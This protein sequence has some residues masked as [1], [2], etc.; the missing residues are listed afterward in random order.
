MSSRKSPNQ[1]PSKCPWILRVGVFFDGTGNNKENDIP[2]GK[3]TNIAKLWETYKIEE[4]TKNLI[5]YRRFYKN[6]VGTIDGDD[7][8]VSGLALG[9]GGIE[10]V[11]EAIKEVADFFDGKPCAKEFVV[12]VFGFSRGA[13]QAR[14]FIN[15]LHDR[16]AGPNVKVGFVGIYDTV[17]SFAGGWIGALDPTDLFSDDEAGDNINR[18]KVS[19]YQGQRKVRR[20][21]RIVEAPYYKD[22][23]KDFNFHLSSASADFI[24]HFVARDEVRKNFPLSSLEPNDGGFL[25]QKTYIGVHSDIGG[26]YATDEGEIK[27]KLDW[28]ARYRPV[29]GARI[30]GLDRAR[31]DKSNQYRKE[32]RYSEAEIEEIKQAYWKLGYDIREERLGLKV[33]LVG[34]KSVANTLSNVYLRLMHQ[35]ACQ[36]QVP[37]E[38]LPEGEE[39]DIPSELQ[40]YWKSL[41]DNDSFPRSCEQEIYA[42]FVHQSDV[43]DEDRAPIYKPKQYFAD[44]ANEPDVG[45]IRTIFT[46]DSTLAVAPEANDNVDA[47][48]AE[49]CTENLASRG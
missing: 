46:N 23:I 11:H 48:G 27:N 38:E 45:E 17:A 20:G 16:A 10:R 1:L 6:G 36:S 42:K 49:I 39:Y 25:N 2:R 18:Y 7:D 35:K 14:H 34:K 15:E 29:H 28:I 43:D 8:E 47:N 19:E 4:D 5:R 13:A 44:L 24:E 31:P 22:I 12:D 9:E 30:G 3:A 37:F 21:R 33:W 32:E 26:G 41:K 40:D